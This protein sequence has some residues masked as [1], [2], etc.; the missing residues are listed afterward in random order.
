MRIV[1]AV[2]MAA[3]LWNQ[4]RIWRELDRLIS[5]TV[6]GKVSEWMAKEQTPYTGDFQDVSIGEAFK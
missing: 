1:C 3:L 6:G 2:C 5:F 4:R